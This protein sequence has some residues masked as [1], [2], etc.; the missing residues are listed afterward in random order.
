MWPLQIRVFKRAA[1]EMLLGPR[2][3]MTA[4]GIPDGLLPERRVPWRRV[5]WRLVIIDGHKQIVLGSWRDRAAVLGGAAETAAT[6]ELSF[7]SKLS[8]GRGPF[9]PQPHWA[10][11]LL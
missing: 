3:E 10:D 2:N 6:E 11:P 7:L 9:L 5:P 1:V 8:A 4:S